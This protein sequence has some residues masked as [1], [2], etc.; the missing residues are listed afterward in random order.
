M[1]AKIPAVAV[2]IV[3]PATTTDASH[4]TTAF[5]TKVKSPMVIIL[6]GKVIKIKKGLIKM[7]ISPMTM[8]AK[9]ADSILAT[10]NPGTIKEA[11]NKVKEFITQAISNLINIINS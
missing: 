9:S 6:S 8:E 5:I 11:A 1:A 7:L 4:K 10:L 3:S 2:S